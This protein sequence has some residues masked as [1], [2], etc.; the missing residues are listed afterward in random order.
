MCVCV[1]TMFIFVCLRM[2]TFFFVCFFIYTHVHFPFVD[3][4]TLTM[5]ASQSGNISEL[6]L[7]EGF[8]HCT[9]W[10]MKNVTQG[11]DKMRAA[12]KWVVLLVWCGVV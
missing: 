3:I 7:S 11:V 12:E 8:A 9:D 1:Y 4:F 5:P 10:S 2:Y 6:L